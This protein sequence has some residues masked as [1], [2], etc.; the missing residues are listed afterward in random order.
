MI[1]SIFF[2]QNRLITYSL[3][4][5]EGTTNQYKILNTGGSNITPYQLVTNYGMQYKLLASETW[6]TIQSGTTL[7]NNYFNVSSLPN[8]DLTPGTYYNYRSYVIINSITYYGNTLLIQTQQPTDGIVNIYS[9]YYSDF[10][11]QGYSLSG[12]AQIRR[13]SDSEVIGNYNL[14]FQQTGDFFGIQPTPVSLP[15]GHTYIIDFG[16]T[17][18]SFTCD[19]TP[20]VADGYWGEDPLPTYLLNSGYLAQ[21]TPILNTTID[22]YIVLQYL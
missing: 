15:L 14:N 5:I 13:L 9:R 10:C 20:V 2:S 1:N 11:T 16:T 18:Y 3:S 12:N 17:R 21:V 22:I 4:T 6:T 7:S 19:M 8:I